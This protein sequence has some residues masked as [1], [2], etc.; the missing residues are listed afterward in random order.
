MNQR[1]THGDMSITVRE[2]DDMTK[3]PR[4]MSA[5]LATP[6]DKKAASPARVSRKSVKSKNENQR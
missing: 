5:K 4:V 1:P 2:H 3:S 6:I